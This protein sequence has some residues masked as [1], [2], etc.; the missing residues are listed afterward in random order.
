MQTIG[1]FNLKGGVAKTTSCWA[2][3]NAL[4]QYMG[5]KVLLVDADQSTD[6]TGLD[7]KSVV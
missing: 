6:L 7:R 1:V 3:G 4:S 5:K 2:L